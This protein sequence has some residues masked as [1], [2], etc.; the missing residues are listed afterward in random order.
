[1]GI[2]DSFN[3]FRHMCKCIITVP[4]GGTLRIL[5]IKWIPQ[6][7]STFDLSINKNKFTYN[8]NLKESIVSGYNNPILFYELNKSD[9][10]HINVM[11]KGKNSELYHTVLKNKEAKEILEEGQSGLML[12]IIGLFVITIIGIGLYTQWEL[13]QSNDKI[14]SLTKTITQLYLNSTKQVIIR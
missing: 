12:I 11:A 1:M 9:P 8:V 7:K 10:M 5:K 4:Y 2:F 14:L 13:S 3:E 6:S